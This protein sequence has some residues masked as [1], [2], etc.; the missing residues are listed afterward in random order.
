MRRMFRAKVIEQPCMLV[1]G[2]RFGH[3]PL[4]VSD[5]WQSMFLNTSTCTLRFNPR[6]ACGGFRAWFFQKLQRFPLPSGRGVGGG[7]WGGGGVG[8]L[9]GVRTKCS[10]AFMLPFLQLRSTCGLGSVS[11]RLYLA[12]HTRSCNADDSA[13]SPVQNINC[14][15]VFRPCCSKTR[16]TRLPSC[17]QE[18]KSS[19]ENEVARQVSL[20]ACK[21]QGSLATHASQ[22]SAAPPSMQLTL[23]F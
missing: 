15:R 10:P 7:G 21:L 23:Y 3:D 18:T 9:G 2:L 19:P 8:V 17:E 14:D 11:L 12:C 16:R 6:V 5:T 22:L 13:L 1:A 4:D 20:Q